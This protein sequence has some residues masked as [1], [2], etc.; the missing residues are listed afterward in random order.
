[1]KNSLKTLCVLVAFAAAASAGFAQAPKI[2]IVDM[3]RLFDSHYKTAEKNVVFQSEQERVKAEI[4]RLNGE[5]LALQEEAQSIAEQLNN[6]V[7]SEDAKV[8]IQEDARAKVAQ[9]QQKQGEMNALVQNSSESLKKRVMNFRSLLMDEIGKVAVEVAKRQGATLLMD[10]SGPSL[11]GM[12]AV[13][14]YEPSLEITDAV[15]AEI[16]KTRPA[17]TPAATTT[18]EEPTVSFPAAGN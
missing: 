8:K 11:L 3:A 17:G 1:M 9:L 12:P 18:G 2:A 6:P 10:K 14:Y 5:G 15:L 13:L 4:N 7:L 16:N